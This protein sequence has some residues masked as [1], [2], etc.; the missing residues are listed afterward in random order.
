[1]V[2][3]RPRLPVEV[4]GQVEHDALVEC[5]EDEAVAVALQALEQAV[6][7]RPIHVGPGAQAVGDERRE[8]RIAG[9]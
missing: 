8:G 9:R 3:E 5:A 2:E 6:A 1:M 7:H 4:D